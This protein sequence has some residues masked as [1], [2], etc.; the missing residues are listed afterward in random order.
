MSHI[1]RFVAGTC[2][3]VV[4]S[5]VGISSAVAQTTSSQ[6]IDQKVE[7]LL[8]KMTMEEKVGQMTQLTLGPF[9]DNTS[10][11]LVLKK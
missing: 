5:L 4:F 3:P 6:D 2:I 1:R 8:K 7:A 9:V 11:T 10:K